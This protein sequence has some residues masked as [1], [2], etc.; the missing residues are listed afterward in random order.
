M[1]FVFSIV[2]LVSSVSFFIICT[3]TIFRFLP[4][5]FLG[6]N[7]NINVPYIP[8]AAVGNSRPPP[9]TISAG[10]TYG[11]PL[12]RSPNSLDP[13]LGSDIINGWP[14]SRFT[15]NL[16]LDFQGTYLI[17]FFTLVPGAT[18]VGNG[19]VAPVPT[20]MPKHIQMGTGFRTIPQQQQKPDLL[21]EAA[22]NLSRNSAQR[23]VYIRICSDFLFI[24]VPKQ[25][26]HL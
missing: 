15:N 10:V 8:R 19:K 11:R 17:F 14:L 7:I 23:C 22:H 18:M 2:Q 6:N 20:K 1:T 12:R 25:S 16:L 21:T 5:F 3:I 24:F 26:W 9:P 13:L 4:L